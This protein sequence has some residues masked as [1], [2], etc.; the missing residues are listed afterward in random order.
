MHE[1]KDVHMIWYL[2]VFFKGTF[3]LVIMETFNRFAT[4][5]IKLTSQIN[6]IVADRS[7]DIMY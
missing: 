7:I 3:T 6:S 1:C 5:R 2:C 4:N